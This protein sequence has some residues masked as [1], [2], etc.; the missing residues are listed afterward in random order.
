MSRTLNDLLDV[1]I[2]HEVL[3]QEMYRAAASR[4][5]DP[6]ARRFLQTLVEEEEGHERTLEQIKTME[7]YDGSIV[8][9]DESIFHP[10]KDTH[11]SS[12]PDVGPEATIEQILELALSREHRARSLFESL[13]SATGN[14]ELKTLFRNLAEEEDSHHDTIIK[15]FKMQRG[16]MGDEMGYDD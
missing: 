3:S 7:V 6:E 13:E 15:R 9:E 11:G 5:S 12:T 16:V 8:L 14:A 2:R 10:E 1:A 4:V